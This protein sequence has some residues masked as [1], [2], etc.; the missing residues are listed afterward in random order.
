MERV[1]ARVMIQAYRPPSF[2]KNGHLLTVY[3]S[4]FRFLPK[5]DYIRERIRTP[6]DDFLDLDWSTVGANHLVIISHGLEGNSQRPYIRGMVHAVNRAGMDALAWN[7]RGCSGAINRSLRFYHS[8]TID[9]LET[10]ISHAV[11]TGRYKRIDLV[12]FS[13]GGNQIILYLARK[14]RDLPDSIQQ[15]IVFSVPLDLASSAEK[16]AQPQN[17]VY[18]RRFMRSLRK[19]IAEKHRM[20]PG[21]LN[22][23][24]LASVKTFSTFDDRYTAPIHGFKNARDYW[25]KCS[26]LYELDKVNLPLTIVNAQDDPFLTPACLNRE[27]VKNPCVEF[28]TPDHG[29]HVGFVLFNRQNMYWSERLVTVRL[30]R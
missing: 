27:A 10:V 13:M 12:G 20:F 15:A 26:S 18:M 6:D 9:D 3:P 11:H 4:L 8:G 14:A 5:P 16:L 28:I 25:Q 21:K 7:F 24:G 23:D 1:A 29:G 2:L 30:S 17:S 22:I 19:K